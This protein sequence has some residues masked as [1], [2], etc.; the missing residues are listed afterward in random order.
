MPPHTKMICYICINDRLSLSVTD[1]IL[2]S[3]R[4]RI[5]MKSKQLPPQISTI[6]VTITAPLEIW[7]SIGIRFIFW[8]QQVSTPS[9]SAPTDPSQRTRKPQSTPC[10]QT[11][12]TQFRSHNTALMRKPSLSAW[13]L[14]SPPTSPSTQVTN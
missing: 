8:T 11:K 5:T 1:R 3:C 7:R 13:G 10:L 14:I 12:A 2:R 4:L 9:T 6:E